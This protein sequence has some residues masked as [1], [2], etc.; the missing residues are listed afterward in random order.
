MNLTTSEAECNCLAY[1]LLM[2]YLLFKSVGKFVHLLEYYIF[3]HVEQATSL[4]SSS[5]D[6]L[7]TAL[8]FIMRIN[9]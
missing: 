9:I 8:G 4:G 2:N 6:L 7:C 3:S 1:E 5:F